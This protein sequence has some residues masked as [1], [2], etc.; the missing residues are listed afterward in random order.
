[1][2]PTDKDWEQ[3]VVRVPIFIIKATNSFFMIALPMQLLYKVRYLPGM[4]IY[5]PKFFSAIEQIKD[6]VVI[7]ITFTFSFVFSY[8][9]LSMLDFKMGSLENLKDIDNKG[10]DSYFVNLMGFVAPIFGVYS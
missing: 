3:R 1:M 10:I 7:F 9:I 4:S 5:L 6:L 2:P 8:T